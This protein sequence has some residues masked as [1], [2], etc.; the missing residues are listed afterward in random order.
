[1]CLYNSYISLKWK[2]YF[3][4]SLGLTVWF[5]RFLHV[6]QSGLDRSRTSR[7]DCIGRLAVHGQVFPSITIVMEIEDTVCGYVGDWIG[8]N[9]LILPRTITFFVM[10]GPFSLTT[11]PKSQNVH[12]WKEQSVQLRHNGK[13][14]ELWFTSS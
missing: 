9:L 12:Y 10:V 1:M 11:H 2:Q 4:I 8:Y 3:F 13:M 14:S 7:T 5:E 6:Y